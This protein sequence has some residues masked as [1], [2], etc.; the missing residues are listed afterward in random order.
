MEPATNLVNAPIVQITA[1]M[2]FIVVII[3]LF[4]IR[5]AMRRFTEGNVKKIV[6]FLYWQLIILEVGLVFGALVHFSNYF[7]IIPVDIAL[8][9]W[10]IFLALM[11]ICGIFVSWNLLKLRK[12][13]N[14]H[15]RK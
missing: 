1:V 6:T 15:P 13:T 10:H 2:A 11:L 12:Y 5:S 14:K 4:S 9:L 3:S 8:D 7:I